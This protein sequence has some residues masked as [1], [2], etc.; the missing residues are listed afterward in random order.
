MRR[1]RP[2]L[3]CA[4]VA[5]AALA[6]L[7]GGCGADA[8]AR[9]DAAA[10]PTDG[11]ASDGGG[12]DA[13]P[14]DTMP[15]ADAPPPDGPFDPCAG[16]GPLPAWVTQ[17][18]GAAR[19]VVAATGVEVTLTVFEPGVVR[20]RYRG[21]HAGD[22]PAYA[23]GQYAHTTYTLAGGATGMTL[24][25]ARA[26]QLAPPARTL[27]ARVRRVDHGVTSATLDG[28]A[29]P[30]RASAAALLAAGTGVYYDAED[31][32][33]LIA[34]PDRAAFTLVL[35]YDPS[36]TEPAGTVLVPLRVTVPAGTPT[37]QPICV[38]TSANGWTHAP[39]TWSSPTTATGVVPVPRGEWFF[40]KLTRGT[41]E[42]VEK[43]PACAEATNRYAFGAAHPGLQATVAGWRD[44]CP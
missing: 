37:D 15:P 40:Y 22:S 39:L 18:P 17:A 38:A 33:A 6:A 29:L 34:F 23:A 43:W 44:W 14:A 21:A 20:L 7:A 25:A 2:A 32:A 8:P 24:G 42:T 19:F 11:R 12:A 13:A 36:L 9:A 5:R 30:V 10:A 3:L 1:P 31:R 27:L 35:A 28:A 41:W 26:G 4:L 16:A